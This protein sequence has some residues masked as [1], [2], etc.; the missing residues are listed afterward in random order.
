MIGISTLKEIQKLF[1]FSQQ[2]AHSEHRFDYYSNFL[3]NYM[4]RWDVP[5]N[6]SYNH[7]DVLNAE[8]EAHLLKKF[9]DYREIEKTEVQRRRFLEASNKKKPGHWTGLFILSAIIQVAIIAAITIFLVAIQLT[10]SEIN[11]M[12]L[13]TNSFEGPSKWF[14][15]GYIMYLTL[16]VAVAVTAVFYNQVEVNMKKE[17]RGFKNI[18]AYIHLFGMNIGG[19]FSTTFMIWFGLEGSGITN[20]ISNGTVQIES[21][22]EIMEQFTG[23]IV[24]AAAFF[25]VGIL[26]GGI[27]FLTTYFQKTSNF[28]DL[29]SR[30][31]FEL[32]NNKTEFDRF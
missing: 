16:V 6:D 5:N 15:F 7:D 4:S 17:F 27:A 30:N 24:A 20:L 26:A 14:F 25:A 12:Q 10:H 28:S 21:Q 23:I 19:A 11:L 3:K 2:Y 31:P 29:N 9:Q 22:I 1:I 32:F 8:Q 18:L 13:L